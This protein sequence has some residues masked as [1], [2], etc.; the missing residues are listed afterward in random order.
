MPVPVRVWTVGEFV[1]LL[2]KD[3]FPE[4]APLDV[5]VKVTVKDADPFA[6]IVTG[7]VIPDKVNSLAMLS[8]ETV[9]AAPVAFRVPLSDELEPTTTLPKLNVAGETDN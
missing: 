1:A 2:A 9:T 6:A 8:D 7:S 5:G 3:R 4:A